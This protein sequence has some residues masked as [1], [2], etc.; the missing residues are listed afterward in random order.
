MATKNEII[1]VIYSSIDEINQQYDTHI[2]KEL[3]TKLFGKES[4]LDSLGLVSLITSIE[5]HIEELTGN[6][7]PIADERALSAETSPFKTVETL[8]DY[9]N[10]LLNE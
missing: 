6:Y 3:N 5:E 2:V 10:L 4:A 7:F 8:T 1:Q 9:I